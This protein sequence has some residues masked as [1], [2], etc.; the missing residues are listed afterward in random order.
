MQTIANIDVDDLQKGIEFYTR[1][2]NLRIG[3]R[4]GGT[5]VELLGASIPIFLLENAAGSSATAFPT[6]SRNYQRHWTPVHLDFVVDE[7]GHAVA[8]ARAAGAKLEG[9]VE[10]HVWGGI[11]RMSDPFGHGFCLL[12]F[13]GEGYDEIARND[14]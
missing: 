12:E 10:T 14:S 3:R 1:G 2:L 8:N 4:L 11:A 6:V 9:E 7:I 13:R 5:I